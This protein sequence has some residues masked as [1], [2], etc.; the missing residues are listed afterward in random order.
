MKGE[1]TL[2]PE[3]RSYQL[4]FTGFLPEAVKRITV[5]AGG[6]T[7]GQ[8]EVTIFYNRKKQSVVVELEAAATAEDVNVFLPGDQKARENA[9]LDRIFACLDQAEIEFCQKDRIYS[10]IQTETRIPVLLTQLCAMEIDT[11]LYEVL[12]ELLTGL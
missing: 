5:T 10:L 2:I 7:L 3:T 9:V 6:R 8:D 1:T 12:L 11:K 4:E